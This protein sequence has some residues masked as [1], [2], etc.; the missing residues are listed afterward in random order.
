[1]KIKNHLETYLWGL[2]SK[3]SVYQSAKELYDKQTKCNQQRITEYENACNQADRDVLH[4]HTAFMKEGAE[5][6]STSLTENEAQLEEAQATLEQLYAMNILHPKYRNFIA[7]TMLLEYFETERCD[8]LTGVNGAYNLY[9]TELRQNLI[10]LKLDEIVEHLDNLQAT[11]YNC[12]A[13]LTTLNQ[14]MNQVQKQLGSISVTTDQQL[15]VQQQTMQLSAATAM[16]SAATAANTE[17]L[18]YITLVS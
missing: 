6:I 18:K 4:E 8:S 5:A 9:E 2:K 7:V 3:Y 16:Y 17:A 10:I 14:Q 12:C 13:A 11:M 15:A 1:M